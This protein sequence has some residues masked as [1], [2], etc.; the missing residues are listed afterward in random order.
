MGN[1]QTDN[2]Q[3][4]YVSSVSA[5]YKHLFIFKMQINYE[6]DHAFLFMT[7][8]SVI[9]SGHFAIKKWTS[10]YINEY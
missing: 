4:S 1:L 8:Y 6:D 9:F 2:K 10:A 5:I 7:L 3:Y